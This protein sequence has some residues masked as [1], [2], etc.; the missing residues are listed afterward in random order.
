MPVLAE[1]SDKMPAIAD[2]WVWMAVLS[3]PV[4]LIAM[5]HR[6]TAVV[7]LPVAGALSALFFRGAYHEACFE[8]S[9]SQAVWLEMGDTWVA[10][11]L[12]SSLLPAV[13]VLLV[14]LLKWRARWSRC[15]DR[16]TC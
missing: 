12:A 9:F 2:M 6:W 16:S 11:S 4:V 13:L 5:T 10:H 15:F 3:I 14:A 8:G 1:I 7:M